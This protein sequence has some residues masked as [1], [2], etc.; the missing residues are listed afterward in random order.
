V[1]IARI[2]FDAIVV[3]RVIGIVVVVVGECGRGR[4]PLRM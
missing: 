3:A 1:R 2:A 4:K